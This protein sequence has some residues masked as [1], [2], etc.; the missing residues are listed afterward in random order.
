[1]NKAW[2]DLEK[3]TAKILKGRRIIR[4]SYSEISPDV[5]LKDFPSFKIDTKRY[6]RFRVFSLYETVKGK[7]CRKHGD[8]PILVLRQHNKVTKLAV[9][10]L[11]LLAKFLDFVREKGGENDFK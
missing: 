10:D 9:I 4:M 8:N 2:K 5:K 11:K 1:M 7:Y 3:T 6:K